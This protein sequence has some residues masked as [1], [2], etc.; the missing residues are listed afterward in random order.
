[1]ALSSSSMT[2]FLSVVVHLLALFRSPTTVSLEVAAVVGAS[3]VGPGP[4]MAFF[5]VDLV[6]VLVLL[7]V[8]EE[9]VKLI[10]KFLRL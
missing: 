7:E 3:V 9:V 6:L 2:V 4:G 5:V 8:A 10:C 1:M